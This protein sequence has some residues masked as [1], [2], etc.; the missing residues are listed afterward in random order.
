MRELTASDLKAAMKFD[1]LPESVRAVLRTRG[2]Q[3]APT[4][5]QISIRL[6]RDVVDSFRAMGDG[7]QT[8]IDAALREWLRTH[9]P[10]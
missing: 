1:Q 10:A 5:E 3:V 7:W 2:P 9:K 8:R 6:S 4:K